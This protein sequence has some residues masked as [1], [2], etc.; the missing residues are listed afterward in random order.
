[1]QKQV[2]KNGKSERKSGNKYEI[3]TEAYKSIS[4]SSHMI[5]QTAGIYIYI[6]IYIYL[7]IYILHTR[8]TAVVRLMLGLS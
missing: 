7:Y 3:N 2:I 6:Y 5:C 4:Y 8:G 1:M